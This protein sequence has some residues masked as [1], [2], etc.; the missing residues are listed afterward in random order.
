MSGEMKVFVICGE[1]SGDGLA[2]DVLNYARHTLGIN[3][4]LYGLGGEKL[5]SLGL[6]SLFDINQLSVLGFVDVIKNI[7]K[8]KKLIEN[9]SQQIANLQPDI[10]LS[11]DSGGFCFRVC[12][13]AKQKLGEAACK[14]KFYHYVAPAVW[15][16]GSERGQ[17]L[18]KIYDKIFCLFNFEPPYFTKYGLE[19]ICVQNP[20]FITHTY[21]ENEINTF[22]KNYGI[23]KPIVCITLGSRRA[24]VDRHI[25]VIQKLLQQNY[26][27]FE[28]YNIIFLCTPQ[29]YGLIKSSFSF[30]PSALILTA[31]EE[32]N[33]AIKLSSF[34]L[35]KSGTNV[36]QFLCNNIKTLVFYKMSWINYTIGKT[37]IKAKFAN[38]ANIVANKMLVPEFVQ[39]KC[40]PK[41]IA[42]AFRQMQNGVFD[43]NF[44]KALLLIKNL[45]EIDV[46]NSKPTANSTVN[47]TA[48][49]TICKHIFGV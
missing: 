6:Q 10:V 32:K 34:A 5:K 47:S 17:K 33:I 7:S 36:M 8:F 39:G 41:L 40:K 28:N 23:T 48:R 21:S 35:A 43:E 38:I 1:V 25:A 15:A 30:L 31:T 11:V 3:F 13:L 20:Y 12:A 46:D 9:T 42:T 22:K 49:Q 14:T 19:A 26:N 24:E 16:Y 44:A 29:F 45:E 2:F 27:V 18:A 4:T 37:F